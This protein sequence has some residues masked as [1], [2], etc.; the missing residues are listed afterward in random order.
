[1]G[2]GGVGGR[3]GRGKV[4]LLPPPI[5]PISIRPNRVSPRGTSDA[6]TVMSNV[7][8]A[9]G[10]SVIEFGT[11]ILTSCGA[12]ASRCNDSV[13]EL[14][15]FIVRCTVTMPGMLGMKRLGQFAR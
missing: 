10:A 15:L 4:R 13:L 6:S 11:V 2:R 14:T 12:F 5:P 3:S 8:L 9:P 1:G 7:A